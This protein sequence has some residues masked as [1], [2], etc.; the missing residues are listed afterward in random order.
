[1]NYMTYAVIAILVV[2]ALIGYMKG[3]VGEITTFIALVLGV[4][5][6]ALVM[7]VVDNALDEEFD[8]A[9]LILLFLLVFIMLVQLIKVLL[10]TVKFLAKLPLINGVNK[11]LGTLLGIAEGVVVVWMCFILISK[12]NVFGQSIAML[13]MIKENKF[14]DFLY[15]SNLFVSFF[16]L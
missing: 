11:L 13:E 14:T 7:L 2:F 4:I 10:K 16:K 9:L 15:D 5:G 1:M 8:D 12:Y 6:L 3:L